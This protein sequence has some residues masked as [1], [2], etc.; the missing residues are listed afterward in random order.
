MI[1]TSEAQTGVVVWVAARRVRRS[2]NPDSAGCAARHR[3]LQACKSEFSEKSVGFHH[4]R[5]RI[6]PAEDDRSFR[7]S[8]SLVVFAHDRV[9]FFT[10]FSA[11]LPHQAHALREEVG[12]MAS[13]FDIAGGAAKFECRLQ[14]RSFGLT[15]EIRTWGPARIHGSI[16]H[17]SLRSPRTAPS[18]VKL[19]TRPG[20]PFWAAAN[21]YISVTP[22]TL[23]DWIQRAR[24]GPVS[25]SAPAGH[26]LHLAA[27]G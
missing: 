27:K 18:T 10:T 11:E 2:T 8:G 24:K 12:P 14:V 21:R 7:C 1:S 15:R 5:P 13:L 9:F 23:A 25:S 22:G 3:R 6:N 16:L 17:P 19:S 20:S 26:P 4:G